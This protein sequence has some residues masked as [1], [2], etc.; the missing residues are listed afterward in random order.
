MNLYKDFSLSLMQVLKPQNVKIDEPMKLHTS[1]KV[2]GAADILVE[3][4]T[5]EEVQKVI[6]LCTD[7][8]IPYYIIGNGSNLIVKDGG[9][10]G[11]VI[12]LSRLKSIKVEGEKIIA[13][14]GITLA[15][16]AREALKNNLE[17]FEFAS[18]IPGSVGGAINMNAGAYGGE[19]S[20]VV[21]S[22]LV[23]NGDGKII[24]ILKEGLD[25][26]YRHSII[27]DQ[28]YV[29]IEVTF[30]LAQGDY[31][32]IKDKMDDLA[33]RRKDKQ[34][35]EYPSAGSTFKRPEGYFTGKLVEESGLKGI[36][37][38]GA[39]VSEKHAGFVIN[40]G[41]A[42]AK[43]ILDLIELVQ[44][45]VRDKFNVELQTEVLIIGED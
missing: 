18:G 3:P 20:Q 44:K 4:E 8:K 39:Q 7:N 9:I 33:K 11:V 6:E 38:G 29:V 31:N 40:K 42:T 13:E 17:G 19:M 41:D 12:K 32:N 27:M 23:I 5:S 28:N 25:L 22:A 24:K 15:A 26:R 37:V 34:P 30:K 36:T 35:L 16:V 21:E 1:F 45:T 14:S 43:D 2:G 10:R